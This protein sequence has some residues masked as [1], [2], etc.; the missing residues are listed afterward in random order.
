MK[1]K[2][3]IHLSMDIWPIKTVNLMISLENVYCSTEIDEKLGI[4]V[5]LLLLP[6]VLGG[7]VPQEV[8]S[9]EQMIPIL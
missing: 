2:E 9:A 1:S 8:I 3:L 7:Y 6:A 5:L 4:I